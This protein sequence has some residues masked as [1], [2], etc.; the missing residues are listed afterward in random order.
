MTFGETKVHEKNVPQYFIKTPKL[1]VDF[2]K[3]K[4]IGVS[5]KHKIIHEWH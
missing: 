3:N 2:Q 4:L 1:Y 5:K